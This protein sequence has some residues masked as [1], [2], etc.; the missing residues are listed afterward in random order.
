[1]KKVNVQPSIRQL[2]SI[3]TRENLLAAGLDIF[4]KYGFQKATISQI[5]KKAKTGYGTAYV[6][7][8]NKDEILIVLMENVMNKFYEIAELSFQPTSK[9]EA[10]K[11]VEKQVSL[12]LVMAG[13]ERAI[14]QVVEE[15]IGISSDVYNKWK[16]IR[17]RFIQRISLDI[18]YSQKTGLARTG[19]NHFLTARSWFFAN[20]MFLWEI[21]RNEQQYSIEEIVYNLTTIYT[22]G[23]YH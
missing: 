17:E 10:H 14:M 3:E 21:V 15:A 5:I 9:Q 18:D 11:M 2:R 12:F 4:V 8:K 23:L 7:F 1:M 19:I 20:E 6:H 16:E 22:E 13:E